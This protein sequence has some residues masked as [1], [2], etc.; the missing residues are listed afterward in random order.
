MSDGGSMTIISLAL[1]MALLAERD[2][3]MGCAPLTERFFLADAGRGVGRSEPGSGELVPRV[4][5]CLG[6][7]GGDGWRVTVVEGN[8]NCFRGDGRGLSSDS[9]RVIVKD[10]GSSSKLSDDLDASC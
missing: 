7:G 2:L 5:S 9:V 10:W 6:F 8:S 4:R 3:S 1:G